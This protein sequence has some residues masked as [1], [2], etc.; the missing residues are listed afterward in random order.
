MRN[1]E[2]FKPGKQQGAAAVQK[3]DLGEFGRL[4]GESHRSLRDDYEVSCDELD[5]MVELAGKQQGVYGARMTGGGFGGCTINLVKS[6]AVADFKKS[7][8]ASYHDKTGLRPEIFVSSA[9]EGASEVP[10]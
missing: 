2:H 6:E 7:V 3:R 5:C 8:S 10:V 4:L 1:S 9:A